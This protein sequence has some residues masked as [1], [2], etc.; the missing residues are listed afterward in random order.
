MCHNDER[1]TTGGDDSLFFYINFFQITPGLNTL[2]MIS[3]ERFQSLFIPTQYRQEAMRPTRS[4]CLTWKRCIYSIAKSTQPQQQAGLHLPFEFKGKS[5]SQKQQ[6]HCKLSE[7]IPS[8]GAQHGTSEAVPDHTTTSRSGDFWESYLALWNRKMNSNASQ[9]VIK[10]SLLTTQDVQL[11]LVTTTE[12]L[13]PVFSITTPSRMYH[14]CFACWKSR[15]S[16]ANTIHS[17]HSYQHTITM[18]DLKWRA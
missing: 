5:S 2:I 6:W 7:N 13:H 11:A 10:A 18:A 14:T 4:I 15:T 3:E 8:S 9:K 1:G 17:I 12:F 16:K